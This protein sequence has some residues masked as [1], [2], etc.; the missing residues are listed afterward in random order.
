[1]SSRTRATTT[2]TTAAV[3]R[4]EARDLIA[5]T[6]PGIVVGNTLMAAVGLALAPPAAWTVI[7]AA[8]VGTAMLIASCGVFNMIVEADSDAR[9]NR[10]R[11]RPVADGRVPATVALVFGTAL[12]AIGTALLFAFATPLAA[13]FGVA[14]C[15]IY[16]AI[17]TPMKRTTWL[18]IPVGAVAGALPPV[19]GWVAAGGALD[20]TVTALFAA[21][22]IWQM[23]HFM[24]IGIRRWTDYRDAGLAIGSRPEVFSQWIVGIRVLS[25]ALV[26]V[27]AAMMALPNVGL[28]FV[29]LGLA[30]AIPMFVA[31]A[32]RA[33]EPITWA[34][35]VFLSSL[36][37]LPL[38][39]VGAF[40]PF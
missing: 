16:V 34:K 1:M 29:I 13:T 18:A 25:G 33:S 38:L 17:Y 9:M 15:I 30:A 28:G 39:A 31:S 6:K 36:L 27:T 5:L 26:A 21:L 20:W 7:L 8:L 40:L 4:I 23:P 12:V 35:K 22:F 19:I 2:T 32:R 14:A 37:Y 3:R 10:T 24:A 11:S